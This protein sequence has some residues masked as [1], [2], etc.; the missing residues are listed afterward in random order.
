MGA[1]A[2]QHPELAKAIV[3]SVGI[4]DMLRV[5]RDPNGA[6]NVT[7]FGSTQDEGQ[8]RSLFAY[9]PYH[10]VVPGAA[11]PAMLLTGG[12]RDPRVEPYHSR[13]MTAAL[14]AAT[15]SSEP[16]LLRLSDSGHGIGSPLDERV[17]MRADIHAFLFQE[18]G[19][20]WRRR[21]HA[22]TRRRTRD[23]I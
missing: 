7:E 14:Q 19:V 6:F 16:I 8:L 22:P 3:S 18:L 10:H 20:E 13:K 5:E 23:G 4:Y 21:A 15:S 2:T 12:R 17:A 1:V 9:S 11:Y